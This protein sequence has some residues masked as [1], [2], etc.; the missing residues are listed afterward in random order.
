YQAGVD[1]AAALGASLISV[2]GNQHTAA[3]QGN[4]CIDDVVNAYLIDLEVPAGRT[5]CRL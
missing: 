1:L 2:E 5:D 4:P 3:L